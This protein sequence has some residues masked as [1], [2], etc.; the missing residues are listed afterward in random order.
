MT[1]VYEFFPK[2]PKALHPKAFWVTAGILFATGPLSTPSTQAQSAQAPIIIEARPGQTLEI[3]E[4]P[5]SP[6]QDPYAGHYQEWAHRALLEIRNAGQ[7]GQY[8]YNRGDFARASHILTE[9]LDKAK[10]LLPAWELGPFSS[11]TIVRGAEFSGKLQERIGQLPNGTIT[12]ASFLLD[13]FKFI[14]DTH[15]NLDSQ[16]YLRFLD[17]GQCQNQSPFGS[18]DFQKRFE[19]FAQAQLNL[20]L[21]KWAEE[22]PGRYPRVFPKGSSVAFF[23]ALEFAIQNVLSD[24]GS[25]YLTPKYAND[26]FRLEQLNFWIKNS[27]SSYPAPDAVE[28]AYREAKSISQNLGN[29]SSDC[30]HGH[31][32][33]QC[34]PTPGPGTWN[35]R[36]PVTLPPPPSSTCP[37]A[38]LPVYSQLRI[39]TDLNFSGDPDSNRY[40]QILPITHERN[41]RFVRSVSFQAQIFDRIGSSIDLEI[42]DDL[43][44]RIDIVTITRTGRSY[45]TISVEIYKHLRSLRFRIRGRSPLRVSDFLLEVREP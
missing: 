18:A 8:F 29:P 12:V 44:S 11:R 10:N 14:Q 25:S 13:Y 41:G 31:P 42:Y 26:L 39:Q 37:P 3:R 9:G 32:H 43:N 6:V 4:R 22:F 7:Q 16:G 20:V 1:F 23:E 5:N 15:Q 28:F 38:R 45:E 24:L 30:S 19:I 36:D 27:S 34:L 40:F 35:P 2:F 33:C 21:N 17:C